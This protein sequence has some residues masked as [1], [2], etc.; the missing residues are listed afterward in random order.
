[1]FLNRAVYADRLRL[2]QV[3]LNL[4]SN[5]IKYNKHDGMVLVSCSPKNDQGLII[6][7]IDTG[8]GIDLSSSESL[9]QPFNRMGAERS[10]IQGTGI[11]LTIAKKLIEKMNGYELLSVLKSSELHRSIP[12]VAVTAKVMIEDVE[13]IESL[14]F[15]SYIAKPIIVNNVHKIIEL[16]VRRPA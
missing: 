6:T 10:N 9:F 7:V 8:C 12:V 14:K 11:G 16:A 5:A 3:L 1:M 13:K 4:L 2:K 15:F